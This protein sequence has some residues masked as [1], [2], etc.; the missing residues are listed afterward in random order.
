[1]NTSISTNTSTNTSI[2]ENEVRHAI[3]QAARRVYH[4]HIKRERRRA[5]D[6]RYREL[7][8][9][10]FG[11]GAGVGVGVG[12][13][14]NALTGDSEITG[15]RQGEDDEEKEVKVKMKMEFGDGEDEDE[16]E[17]VNGEEVEEEEKGGLLVDMD[18]VVD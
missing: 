9:R 5:F 10:F 18:L 2:L 3:A 12:A 17:E 1:M 16:D 8:V 6:A 11:Q 7:Q 15:G 14:S 4:T 13:R